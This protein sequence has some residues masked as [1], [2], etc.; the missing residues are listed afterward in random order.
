M[1]RD[2][3][4]TA[5]TPYD[6]SNAQLLELL[7]V[8]D[9]AALLKVSR[10]WVYEHTRTRGAPRSERIPH[11]KIGKYVRFDPRL[12]R[13]FIDRRMLGRDR[14]G[15]LGATMTSELQHEESARGKGCSR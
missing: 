6:S 7:T 1:P 15:S 9:V 14:A 13:A 4:L 5:V 12:V 2:A 3:S 10:S 8:D 11:V